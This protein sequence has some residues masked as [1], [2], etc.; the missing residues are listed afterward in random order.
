M[1][2]KDKNFLSIPGWG[3]GIIFVLII[4]LIYAPGISNRGIMTPWEMDRVTAAVELNTNPSRPWMSVQ[5]I[6]SEGDIAPMPIW[7][8]AIGYK[9]LGISEAGGRIGA[10]ILFLL[11]LG[12]SFWCISRL[13]D[14]RTAYF[15]TLILSLFPLTITQVLMS[16]GWGVAI[17]FVTIALCGISL[18]RY[19]PEKDENGRNNLI[20]KILGLITGC[21]GLIGGYFSIGGIIGLLMPLLTIVITQIVT[22]DWRVFIPGKFREY[23]KEEGIFSALLSLI[24]LIAFVITA[25]LVIPASLSKEPEFNLLAGGT[26]RI[27]AVPTIDVYIEHIAF[28]TYP[29]AALLPAGL[30]SLLLPGVFGYPREIEEKKQGGRIFFL[31]ANFIGFAAINFFSFRYINIPYVVLLPVAV[32]CGVLLRD[33]EQAT[34]S[35]KT[36][37]MISC[38]FLLLLM[39]DLHLYPNSFGELWVSQTMKDAYPVKVLSRGP[40][41][42]F[43]FA[44][45]IMLFY[46]FLIGSRKTDFLNWFGALTGSMKCLRGFYGKKWKVTFWVMLVIWAILII[47]SLLIISGAPIRPFNV[48]T[49]IAKKAIFGVT[50]LPILIFI[51]D[52]AF[53]LCYNAIA[54]AK[55]LRIDLLI[56]AGFIF[57]F[58]F[59]NGY[60]SSVVKNLSPESAINFFK[61]YA[62]PESE[63]I[64]FRVNPQIGKF[65]GIEKIK[66]VTNQSTIINELSGGKK[67]FLL[68]AREDNPSLDLAYKEKNHNH[69]YVPEA[70][71]WRFL[72]ASGLKI[73]KATQQN[74]IR[75]LVRLTPPEPEYNVYANLDNKLEYLGYDLETDHEGDWAGA[76]EHFTFRSYWH[77]TD[78]IPGSYKIFIH[79]DGFGLRLNGDHE[80]LDELYPTRYWRP[81]D[82][83]VDTYRMQVPI[84]FRAGDYTIYIGLFQGEERLKQVAGPTSG[85]DRIQGGILRVR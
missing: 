34:A 48:L 78:K 5:H 58:W 46:V 71:T 26:P 49:S 33:L 79:V 40:F 69:M 66:Q 43:T 14:I 12:I 27:G 35:W 47:S 15:S 56:A 28:G 73:P 83:L 17:S 42:F 54:S 9:L 68:Y 30:A 44:Y 1:N 22:S 85:D 13:I 75:N 2:M 11:A 29:W 67:V 25:C 39:R 6:E 76:L 70:S 41:V 31:I 45:M 18:A 24:F 23:I 64:T 63:L 72:L 37:G 62:E 81:G 84:H 74:P 38:L 19:L 7:I 51:G 4:L 16:G 3:W 20:E 77:C 32:A 65:Y 52:F 10:V 60:L 80:P 53:R 59:S 57:G 55:V 82:Y 21:I 36:V 8:A 50:L 61:K